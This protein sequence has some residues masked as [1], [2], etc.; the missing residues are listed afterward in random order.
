MKEGG[1]MSRTLM[2]H[3]MSGSAVKRRKIARFI[4]GRLLS[5][6]DTLHRTVSGRKYNKL[7]KLHF[8]THD[9][10]ARK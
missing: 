10:G 5:G 4:A 1:T 9:E 6:I 2:R 7:L 3:A 8:R